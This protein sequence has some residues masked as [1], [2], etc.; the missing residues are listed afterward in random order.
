MR[1]GCDGD[2]RGTAKDKYVQNSQNEILKELIKNIKNIYCLNFLVY[3]PVV[4][5]LYGW[6]NICIKKLF[7]KVRKMVQWIAMLTEQA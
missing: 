1:A 5:S 6:S 4:L 3:G 7:A 2:L